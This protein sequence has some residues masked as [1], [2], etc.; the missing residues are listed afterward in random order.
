MRVACKHDDRDR[1]RSADRQEATS[2]AAYRASLIVAQR[3]S[4]ARVEEDRSGFDPASLGFRPE[5]RWRPL[6][7]AVDV[8]EVA[9]PG[10][11]YGQS[12]MP[13][14]TEYYYWRGSAS[15]P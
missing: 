6:D 7:P 3:V 14:A 1:A 10:R 15:A 8:I 9:V 4:L 5:P 13:D 11:D 12:Y 2:V